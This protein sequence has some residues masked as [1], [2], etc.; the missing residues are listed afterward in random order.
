MASP[1]HSDKKKSPLAP[2]RPL[3]IM[4]FASFAAMYVLM[5]AMVDRFANVYSNLNQLYMAGLM[6]APMA[7]L[8][9]L[10]MRSMYPNKKL[11]AVVLAGCALAGG[12][13]WTLIRQQ[14]AISDRQFLKS[15]IPHH[16]GALLMCKEASLRDP[17]LVELCAS[18]VS[19]QQ[20]EIDLMRSK[21]SA[22]KE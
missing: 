21:L 11:N 14:T 13:F 19:G 22:V 7:I 3:L 15:M 18:I 20:S 1:H 10:L 4:S 2:Y 5:Y 9:I 12:A 6:T 17:A 16:A 8:E